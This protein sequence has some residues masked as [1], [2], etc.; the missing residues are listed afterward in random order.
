M[1]KTRRRTTQVPTRSPRPCAPARAP[2]GNGRPPVRGRHR[3]WVGP[4]HLDGPDAESACSDNRIME[5]MWTRGCESHER[6]L[7][8]FSTR[9][10]PFSF[11]P[12]CANSFRWLVA[13]LRTLAPPPITPIQ[14]SRAGPGLSPGN[15]EGSLPSP[16]RPSQV[17]ERRLGRTHPR[18][19][20][21][22]QH[23]RRGVRDR[24]A[25]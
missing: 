13:S 23:H 1:H 11:R 12:G 5:R 8:K 15:P 4:K 25:R 14:T 16:T 18:W 19:R 22:R 20:L 6:R 3:A 21:R 10:Q 24:D 17:R 2:G 9:K 7:S